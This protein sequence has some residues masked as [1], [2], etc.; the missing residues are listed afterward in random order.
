MSRTFKLISVL[1]V[2]TLL[3]L[4]VAT[5]VRAFESR[6]GQNIVIEKGEVVEDDLYLFADTIVV[7]GTIKGDLVAFGSNIT[8]NGTVEGDV[9]AAGQSVVINGNVKDDARSAGA[10]LQVGSSAVIGDDLIAAGASLETQAGSTVGGDLVSGS[11]QAL[12]AGDVTGDVTVGAAGLALRGTYGGDVHAYVDMTSDSEE[13]PPLNMY[14]TDMPI[15]IPSVPAG[16][17]VSDSARIAGDLE[18]TSTFDLDIPSG[19]VAGKITRTEPQVDPQMQVVEQTSA[20]KVG[21]WALG[22]LRSSVTLILFGLFLGWLFPKFMKLLPETL[23][24]KPWAS[25]GWGAV[26]W[27][28]FFFALLAV[29]LA[30]I[31]GGI[32]F[33]IFTLGAVTGTIIWVGI[34][35]LFAMTV[36]F[37]L[38]TSYLTK[39][40]VGEWIGKW[41][42]SKLNPSLSEHK[43]WPMVLGVVIVVAV[44]GLLN[45]P[46]VPLGFFGWLANFA[47]ILFGLGTLWLWGREKFAKQPEVQ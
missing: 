1:A 35:L 29:I 30:M 21:T 8:V 38:A 39:I 28:V 13:M 36:G 17:T 7:N 3:A 27:A 42:L 31:F 45:F 11:A 33:G 2:L 4:T 41:I 19:T 9:M 40:V 47:V 12:L 16:L 43:V 23:R 32:L 15:S 6:E 14:M 34:L 25:L 5:P 10:G 20:Q 46:L 18:Y 44:I 22:L 37:V 24:V 26:A